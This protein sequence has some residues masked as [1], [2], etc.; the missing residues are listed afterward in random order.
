MKWNLITNKHTLPKLF[1]TYMVTISSVESGETYVESRKVAMAQF[2]R[3]MDGY[4]WVYTDNDGTNTLPNTCE[5]SWTYDGTEYRES[6]VAWADVVPYVDDWTAIYSNAMKSSG[7]KFGI[8]DGAY[9]VE[10]KGTN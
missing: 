10:I 7:V 8:T 3:A 4:R 9:T 1:G 6:I 2:Q 5:H